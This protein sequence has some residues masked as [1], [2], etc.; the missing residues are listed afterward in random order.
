MKNH[1]NVKKIRNFVVEMIQT[2]ANRVFFLNFSNMVSSVHNNDAFKEVC[3][4]L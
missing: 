3:L 1:Q 2:E 4:C